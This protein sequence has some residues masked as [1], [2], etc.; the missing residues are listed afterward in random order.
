M[1]YFINKKLELEGKINFI[2]HFAN[3]A[4]RYSGKSNYQNLLNIL[5]KKRHDVKEDSLYDYIVSLIST[6][7]GI[8][9]I[10]KEKNNKNID[11][12][13]FTEQDKLN[14]ENSIA[15][16]ELRRLFK[17]LKVKHILT[18]I[19]Y[20][21]TLLKVISDNLIFS[22]YYQIQTTEKMSEGIFIYETTLFPYKN[23]DFNSEEN[24]L[25]VSEI[26]SFMK[27]YPNMFTSKQIKGMQ[28]NR[29]DYSKLEI[30]SNSSNNFFKSFVDFANEDEFI[31]YYLGGISSNMTAF[32]EFEPEFF[33]NILMN[34]N[35][36]N[37]KDSFTVE[38]SVGCFGSC[39]SGYT[40]HTITVL[41]LD[42]VDFVKNNLEKFQL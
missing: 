18:K 27:K 2:F 22:E 20:H 10:E 28:D 12:E 21:L 4:D 40:E 42:V 24:S 15:V 19:F 29:E 13:N 26:Q 11:I 31:A 41:T 34:M 3:F 7:D 39:E 33:D 9:L 32:L 6:Y 36:T 25:M 14:F 1:T 16:K 37:A 8:A 5:R 17:A 38:D 23:L 30:L 35:T